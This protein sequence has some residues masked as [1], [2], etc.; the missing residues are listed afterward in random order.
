MIKQKQSKVFSV[1][2]AMLNNKINNNDSEQMPPQLNTQLFDMAKN[3][4]SLREEIAEIKTIFSNNENNFGSSIE[5]NNDSDN[6]STIENNSTID[7]DMDH[8]LRIELIGMI[9]S[10]SKAKTELAA[11]KHPHTDDDRIVAASNELDEI[12]L[13]T[14]NATNNILESTERVEKE[15]SHI[16]A[17]AHDDNDILIV[18]DKIASE[19]TNILEACSFQDITGQ[20]IT[21]VVSTMKFLEDRI[22]AMIDIWGAES[23]ID[24]PIVSH[25]T[26]GNDISNDDKLL[27]G[28]QMESEAISQA[29]IDALFD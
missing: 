23:L 21:K 17:L 4:E 18:A 7:I 22:L 19:I 14:E 25:S 8:G 15:L 6:N 20:R 11:I 24:I 2:R 9:R 12:V 29:D 1:E 28:P 16:A 27:N 13:A 3:I 26:S 5:K 10:V